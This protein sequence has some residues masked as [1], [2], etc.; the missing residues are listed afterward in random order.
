MSWK[1]VHLLASIGDN[2]GCLV[3]IRVGLWVGLSVG[4]NVGV[5]VGILSVVP[6]QV[7][8]SEFKKVKIRFT[9]N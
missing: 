5:R 9:E 6:S 4:G 2:V 1:I 8:L 3:G 7:M